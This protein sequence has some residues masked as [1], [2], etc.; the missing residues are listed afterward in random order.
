MSIDIFLIMSIMEYEEHGIRILRYY[1][2][3]CGMPV[4]YKVVDRDRYPSKTITEKV[5]YHKGLH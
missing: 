3:Q 2:E 5:N 1:C 4:S